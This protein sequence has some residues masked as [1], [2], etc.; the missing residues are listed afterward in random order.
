MTRYPPPSPLRKG[1]GNNA[2][3][4][5]KS[6]D[7]RGNPLCNKN[8]IDCHES[9]LF[10]KSLDSRNDGLPSI[11]LKLNK[12]TPN[13]FISLKPPSLKNPKSTHPLAPSARE[14]GIFIVIARFCDFV[15][16]LQNRGN[17]SL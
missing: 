2:V 7:L 8:K 17:L 14:E 9:S 15:K 10:N 6:Q 11:N 1:W 3:I 5:S 16:K 12:P 13:Q 4:A